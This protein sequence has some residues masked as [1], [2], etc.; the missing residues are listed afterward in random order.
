VAGLL[1][2]ATLDRAAWALDY[3]MRALAPMLRDAEERRSHELAA[4]LREGAE[5]DEK[6]F[7][8]IQELR[9]RRDNDPDQRPK[10]IKP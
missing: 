3:K 2:D 1:S 10:R 9:A 5:N 6:A 4:A 7:D 8:E